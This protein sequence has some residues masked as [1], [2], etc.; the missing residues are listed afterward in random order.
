MGT[1]EVSN[2]KVIEQIQSDDGR[3][4]GLAYACFGS[5]IIGL[6]YCLI[7]GHFK[8]RKMRFYNGVKNILICQL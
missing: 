1:V 4:L 2:C 8:M 7:Y 5:S 6:E 3:N